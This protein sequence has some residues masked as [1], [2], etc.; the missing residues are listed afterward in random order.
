MQLNLPESKPE[1][2]LGSDSVANRNDAAPPNGRK[3]RQFN[4]IWG[5]KGFPDQNG[6]QDLV[7]LEGKRE[8]ARH[9]ELSPGRIIT[10]PESQDLQRLVIW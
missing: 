8:T 1:K 5:E 2:Q 7:F 10:S 4:R 6:G 3:A 9:T